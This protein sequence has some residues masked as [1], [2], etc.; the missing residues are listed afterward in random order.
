MTI[1][2]PLKVGVVGLG[3][4]VSLLRVFD[5]RKDTQVVAVCD[6]NA[7]RVEDI[8]KQMNIKKA[9]SEYDEFLKHDMDIVVVATPLPYH[10][11][12]A[13]AALEC[14]KHV[15]SEVP[16]ANS[17]QEC[18]LLVKAVKNSKGKFMFAEN[19]NYWYFVEKWRDIVKEG[20]LG[21]PTYAEAEYVHDCRSIMR[22]SQGNF[23]WRASMPPIYY[24]TH[25]LGPILSILDD[26]CLTAVG[27]DTGVNVAPDLG[28]IDMEVGLFRTEK[29][30]IIKIL[31][32]FSVERKPAFHFYSIYGT[33]G[34]LE[35]IRNTDKFSAYLKEENSQG[36]EGLPY[37][38]NH[39]Q[40]PESATVG[41]HGTCEY[42][43]I[44]AFVE[45]LL[46]NQQPPIDVYKGLDY[47]LPGLCAHLSSKQG[48]KTVDIPD[49]R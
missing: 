10:V 1:S 8:C 49:L 24:C 33:G 31:C 22:D 41:G 23:T 19:C 37:G 43:M 9:Y 16:I 6:L 29:G 4:G 12:N 26:K 45:S 39:P 13:I 28:A 15:L 47:S 30:A 5:Q 38:R 11:E 48:G 36:M 46:N 20:K 25:S 7:E 21:K 32:G 42:Y 35:S 34:C 44:D 2:T 3:R 17:I 14:D 40:A 18:E 27:M